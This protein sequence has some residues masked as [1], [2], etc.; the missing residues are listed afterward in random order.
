[1]KRTFPNYSL[2]NDAWDQWDKINSRRNDEEDWLKQWLLPA[3][4]DEWLIDPRRIDSLIPH[5]HTLREYCLYPKGDLLLFR[6]EKQFDF[7]NDEFIDLFLGTF[8]IGLPTPRKVPISWDEI[9]GYSL[10]FYHQCLMMFKEQNRREMFRLRKGGYK[11][12]T[13]RLVMT[14]EGPLYYSARC[15]RIDGVITP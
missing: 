12:S 5:S 14:S 13:V 4:E 8:S 7:W 11:F 10:N 9:R 3:D 6:Y 15:S 1:M 2:A